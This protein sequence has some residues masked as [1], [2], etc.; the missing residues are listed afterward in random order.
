M[1]KLTLPRTPYN[2]TICKTH[3]QYLKNTIFKDAYF[4]VNV[5]TA[6]FK[7]DD[8]YMIH[9]RFERYLKTRR[10]FSYPYM[11]PI[12][13]NQTQYKLL[14]EKL[15]EDRKRTD[16]RLAIEMY[17]LKQEWDHSRYLTSLKKIDNH[18]K[19]KIKV[20]EESFKKNNSS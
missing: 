7:L 2:D 9:Q 14:L 15:K 6:P 1:E 3:H 17:K 12:F 20:I 8:F 4:D 19:Q 18:C 13:A 11:S 10:Y 16:A 5:P